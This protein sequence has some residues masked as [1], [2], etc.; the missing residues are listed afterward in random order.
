MDQLKDRNKNMDQEQRRQTVTYTVWGG[1]VIAA[2]LLLTTVWVSGSARTGTD[3][4]VERVSEFY[5]D[6][7]AGRRAQVVSEEL[8]NYTGYMERAR[9][10][11]EDA[12]LE[13]Q[14][15]LRRFLGKVE[16]LY[17]VD[18][19][20]M[21][22][23]NGIVYSE[24]STV[25]GLSRY[26]FLSEELT[27]PVI[28]TLNLYGA[29]KQVLLATP[30]EDVSFQGVRIKAC[31]IQLN[32]ARM[33]SSLTLQTSGSETYY[34]LYYRNGESLTEDNFGYLTAGNNLLLSLK[35]AKMEKES[36]Y[37]R[38]ADDF[39]SGRQGQISFTYE[40]MKEGLC[41]I[42]V[43]GTNWMLTILIRNNVISEQIS[44]ISSGMMSRGIIQIFITVFSM[45]VVFLILIHQSRKNAM[46]LLEQEKED[47]NRI[48]AA[49]VQI[50]REQTDMIL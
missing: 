21:V 44:S 42:P 11:L 43:E 9:E 4:A 20:A 48:R 50:E 13:S 22:D 36:D 45:L 12:D 34:N 24:N 25:S 2:V 5:L 26:S 40:E 49:Y 38:F 32:I 46:I 17:D 6:E 18:K 14:E 47:G 35:D 16:T 28:R 39:L 29:K 19:F 41:Y 33:L 23:E 27:E 10:I 8:K 31:F 7:L 37:D 3:Q 1:L 30:V 15:T